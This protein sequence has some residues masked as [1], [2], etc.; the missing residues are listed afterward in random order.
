MES[1]VPV[2]EVRLCEGCLSLRLDSCLLLQYHDEHSYE[3]MFITLSPEEC[4]LCSLIGLWFRRR[5]LAGGISVS[6]ND[7]KAFKTYA[8][9][10][11]RRESGA[12][13]CGIVEVRRFEV[14]LTSS[15]KIKIVRLWPCSYPV[16]SIRHLCDT[17]QNL[18]LPF[19][20]GRLIEPFVDVRLFKR[21]IQQCFT[22]HGDVCAR[23]AWTLH[24][25]DIP[26]NFRLVDIQAGCIVDSPVKPTYF[27]LSYVWGPSRTISVPHQR[28]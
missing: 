22:Q 21:W 18:A 15:P 25:D 20:T 5:R 13:H 10:T 28:T 4:S 12:L 1:S 3:S 9:G 2:E 16:P 14:A 27:A 23:P 19:P 7:R 8:G 6:E 24:D 26:S 17:N 11:A